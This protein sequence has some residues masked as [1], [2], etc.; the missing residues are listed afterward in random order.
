MSARLHS[1]AEQYET[2]EFLTAD[3]SGFMHRYS[4]R[5]D[6]E[7]VA[8][9]S[10]V[11]AFGKRSEIL[12]HIEKFLAMFGNHSPSEWLLAGKHRDALPDSAKSFYR[13]FTFRSLR[14]ACETLADII[15][16]H[17][18]L[19]ECLRK[20]HADGACARHPG[21]LATVLAEHFPDCCSPLVAKDEHCANK[22]LNLFLRWMV[23]SHSPV[24]LGLWTWY[25]ATELIMP[26]DTHVVAMA[27]EFGLLPPKAAASLKQALALTDI[28]KSVFPEDPLKGDFALFG[29]GVSNGI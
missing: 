20:E 22:R 5:R 21:R 10:A 26:M 24:D 27:K 1:L 11:L 25:P 12:S 23:R 14:C 17:G 2:R 6:V 4:E 8:F 28:M 9:I 19:G 7:V 15:A 16:K 29:Y 13:V 18:S 3:P